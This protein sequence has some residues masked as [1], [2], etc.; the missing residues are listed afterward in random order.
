MK[1]PWF[2]MPGGTG[3]LRPPVFDSSQNSSSPAGTQIGGGASRHPGKSA[4][5]GPGS[6]TA[7]DRM[8]A[9][10]VAPFSITHTLSSGLSCL[11]RIANDNPAGPAPTVTTSYSITSRSTSLMG[12][13]RL[14]S[15]QSR[16]SRGL[17]TGRQIRQHRAMP[18]T[19]LALPGAE[20]ALDPH[21][22]DGAQADAL[23]A[24]LLADVPWEVHRIRLFGREVDSP[25]RSCWI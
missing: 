2:F 17:R 1:L 6:I 12:R 9:P 22:L 10:T 7:P 11:S 21:W 16:D 14:C 20:L 15:L 24:A 23:V 18:L 8:C 5:S 4:S 19:P 13:S 3:S 25:R